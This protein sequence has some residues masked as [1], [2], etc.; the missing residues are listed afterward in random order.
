MVLKAS[1]MSEATK[2]MCYPI[3]TDISA[4]KFLYL[5]LRDHFRRG[6]TKTV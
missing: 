1:Q 4:A 5:S 3:P 2:V 6:D